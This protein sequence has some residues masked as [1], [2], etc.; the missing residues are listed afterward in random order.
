MKTTILFPAQNQQYLQDIVG[1]TFLLT[2]VTNI[3]YIYSIYFKQ[4]HFNRLLIKTEFSVI[5][6]IYFFILHVLSKLKVH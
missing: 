2:H 3:Y 5:Y 1:R 6:F 4:K